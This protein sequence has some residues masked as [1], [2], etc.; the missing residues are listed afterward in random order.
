MNQQLIDSI[1]Q[2]LKGNSS[3]TE[4][5]SLFY[6]L[7][8]NKQFAIRLM[9]NDS[10]LNRDTLIYELQKIIDEIQIKHSI[11]TVEDV[12]TKV[13]ID[14]ISQLN[15][16]SV[17]ITQKNDIEFKMREQWKY[18]YRHRG[19]LHGRLHEAI[20]NELRHDIA[21]QIM[22]TQKQIDTLNLELS[23]LENGEIP[24]RFLENKI[25]ST[26]Y[27]AIQ[28]LKAYIRRDK[29][30]LS[31]EITVSER[32]KLLSNIS[33]YEKKIKEYAEN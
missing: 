22:S 18:L 30:R 2:Y 10:K 24:I 9:R 21:I 7:T 11:E 27:R 16:P 19:H 20:T 4:G 5:C 17:S 31:Q 33:K 12:L 3:Y 6:S 23:N 29:Y 15:D 13:K 25:S 26:D 32:K 1:N 28:N 14:N 8:T